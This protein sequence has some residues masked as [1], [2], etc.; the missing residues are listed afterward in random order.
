MTTLLEVMSF[1][2]RET[3]NVRGVFLKGDKIQDEI[4]EAQ[5]VWNFEF[6]I[7]KCSS[8]ENG[9]VIKVWSLCKR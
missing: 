4:L 5:Q 8:L 9:C 6:E 7:F 1:V 3:K 2:S